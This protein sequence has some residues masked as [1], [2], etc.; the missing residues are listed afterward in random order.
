[1]GLISGAPSADCAEVI[2][3]GWM[4]RTRTLHSRRVQQS[5]GSLGR[6]H[7]VDAF[8]S[9]RSVGN[10]SPRAF[11]VYWTLK[12]RRGAAEGRLISTRDLAQDAETRDGIRFPMR[13]SMPSSAASCGLRSLAPCLVST[14]RSAGVWLTLSSQFS[15]DGDQ[16]ADDL[17]TA[18]PSFG[19]RVDHWSRR[20]LKAEPRMVRHTAHDEK[21]GAHARRAAAAPRAHRPR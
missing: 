6:R 12:K 7:L 15:L 21:S 19:Q 3:G 13:R 10:A 9:Q 14:R 20:R 17:R 11:G 18:A 1:M 5:P 16:D 8:S 2:G 4:R